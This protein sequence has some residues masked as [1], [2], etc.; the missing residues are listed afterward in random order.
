MINIVAGPDSKG[1]YLFNLEIIPK[2]L[3]FGCH[4]ELSNKFC[5]MKA[6]L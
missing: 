2:S 5:Q 4:L 1:I 3:P 6:N